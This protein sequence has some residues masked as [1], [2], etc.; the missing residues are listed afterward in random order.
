MVAYHFQSNAILVAPFQS[1]KDAHLLGD[2][3]S[4]IQHLKDK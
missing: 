4:I 3:T 1:R 2:Y